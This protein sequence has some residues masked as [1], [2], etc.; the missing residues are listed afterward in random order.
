MRVQ[1][2]GLSFGQKN[3]SNKKTSIIGAAITGA[4]IG[5]GG[6]LTARHFT[7]ISND[8][9]EKSAKNETQN[10]QVHKAVENFV[11]NYGKQEIE[12]ARI[13]K[14]AFKK[15]NLSKSL[16][17]QKIGVKRD[18]KNNSLNNLLKSKEIKLITKEDSQELNNAVD[19]LA[20]ELKASLKKTPKERKLEKL[21]DLSTSSKELLNDAKNSISIK[22]SLSNHNE[23]IKGLGKKGFQ[24]LKTTKESIEKSVPKPL[25]SQ[26]VNAF[27]S[28][29]RTAA[30][31]Q[32]KVSLWIGIP[33]ALVAGV[34]A[35]GA[36][37]KKAT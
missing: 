6:G 17:L 7:P 28:M 1:G 13:L 27:N 9:F 10:K 18:L 12:D 11:E 19:A 35:G 23:Q 32:R 4:T 3:E 37:A 33:A 2:V 15:S 21:E 25:K 20:K 29:V 16:A 8:F 22:K 5:A 31:T 26:M 24:S 14:T 34:F 30:K 36:S